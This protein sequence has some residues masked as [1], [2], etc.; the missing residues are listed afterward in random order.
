MVD[1]M[2]WKCLELMGSKGKQVSSKSV[3][4]A[5]ISMH[6]HCQQQLHERHKK[7][8]AGDPFPKRRKVT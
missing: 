5:K 8:R 7:N 4:T 1:K 2:C 6:P 3:G